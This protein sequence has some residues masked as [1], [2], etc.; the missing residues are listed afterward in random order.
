MPQPRQL[1]HARRPPRR[2]L[3]RESVKDFVHSHRYLGV[4]QLI[5]RSA[6]DQR[7]Q[8][9]YTPV[10]GIDFRFVRGF[11]VSCNDIQV[12]RFDGST[13]TIFVEWQYVGP[14]RRGRSDWTRV[15]FLVC[16]G[17]RKRFKRLY[18]NRNQLACRECQHIPY[19]SQQCSRKQRKIKRRAELEFRRDHTAKKMKKKTLRKF[20][21]Q[22]SALPR[23]SLSKRL[24]R[25]EPKPL[26]WYD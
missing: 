10:G 3:P 14:Y 23:G 15:A 26:N 24:S 1:K 18:W 4:R 6:F 17:C 12:Y 2:L 9:K 8:N 5:A 19:D 7:Q 22:I 20:E 11:D 16:F 13:Q 21:L 25:H